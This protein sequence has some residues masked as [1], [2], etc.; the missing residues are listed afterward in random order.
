MEENVVFLAHKVFN[1]DNFL[2]HK[3]FNS[4][5]FLAH[6]VFNSDNFPIDP[7]ARNAKVTLAEKPERK[8]NGFLNKN[9][10]T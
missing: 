7:S 4:D 10:D 2:A 1:S 3:V 5:N 6:K 9:I 8:R